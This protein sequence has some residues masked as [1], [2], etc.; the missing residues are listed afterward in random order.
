MFDKVA[1][2]PNAKLPGTTQLVSLVGG[3]TTWVLLACVV[4]VLAGAAAWGF[5]SRSGH[6][7]ATQNGRMMVLGGALGALVAGAAS[8]LVN[9]G[10]SLG[11]TVH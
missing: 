6:F 4:A 11:G 2:H 7:G 5:G 8:A 1:V 3:M 10:F 9:F